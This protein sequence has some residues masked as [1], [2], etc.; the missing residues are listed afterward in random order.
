[1]VVGAGFG[2]LVAV[3]QLA[4]VPVEVVVVDRI[5]HHLFQSFF[6]QVA[7]GFL[8]PGEIASPIRGVFRR[9]PNT[10]VMVGEVTDVDLLRGE[11]GL[12]GAEGVVRRLGYD[13]LIVA[14][15]VWDSYFGHEEWARCALLM[16][17]L[18]R[19]VV[20]CDRILAAYERATEVTEVTEVTDPRQRRRWVRFVIVGGGP[21][22]VE[23][24]GQLA[25]LA[26]QLC[27]DF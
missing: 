23:L 26:R 20:L 8:L 22:G 19:A 5:N 17:T 15:G 18:A 6:Y 9:Q 7:I 2:G 21:T 12:C 25:T 14:A 3:R 24:A 27:G 13:Y 16:K 11:I 1:M 10:M 4:R